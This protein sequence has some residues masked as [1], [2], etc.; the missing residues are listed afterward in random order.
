MPWCLQITRNEAL[1]L[2]GR[3]REVARAEPL[4]EETD[5]SDELAQAEG[6]RAL[7][8]IDL[9]RALDALTPHERRLITLRYVSD[10]SHP[11][12]A[13][14]LGIPEATARVHLHRAHKHLRPLL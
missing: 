6:E 3:R 5:L 11:E 12:I 14:T 2:I 10:W 7:A 8:R 9:N 4:D 13:R 1:R